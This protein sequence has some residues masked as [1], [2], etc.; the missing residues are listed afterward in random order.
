MSEP[1]TV[2]GLVTTLPRN[3]DARQAN[4][5]IIQNNEEYRVLPRGA[6]IDLM[7]EVNASVEAIGL[8]T[9]EDGLKYIAV[10]GFKLLE[11]DDWLDDE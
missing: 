8:I 3:S 2:T 11:D 7:D 4:V 1:L 9:E 10:R 6:G 5:A